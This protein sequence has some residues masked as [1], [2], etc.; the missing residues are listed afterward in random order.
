VPLD[1]DVRSS[2]THTVVALAGELDLSTSAAL[3]GALAPFDR[4]SVPVVVDLTDVTFLDSSA[5]R[6]LVQARLRLSEAEGHADL[7]L[8]VTRDNL[9]RVLDVSGL[10]EVFEVFD[11]EEAA[12]AGR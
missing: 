9:R 11:T 1:V 10:A 3:Q 2:A 12:A 4:S 8:V 7:R 6:V 5:L